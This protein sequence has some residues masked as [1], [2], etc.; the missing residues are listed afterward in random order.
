MIDSAGPNDWVSG[1]AVSGDT[2]LTGENLTAFLRAAPSPS[3]LSPIGGSF[4]GVLVLPDRIR[5]ISDRFGSRPVFYSRADSGWLVASEFWTLADRL[6]ALVPSAG[7]AV[8]MLAFKFIPGNETISDRISETA[9]ATCLDLLDNGQVEAH[10]Y[11]QFRPQ[12]HERSGRQLVAELADVIEGMATRSVHAGSLMGLDRWGINLTAG[13]DS[14]LILAGLIRA[15]VPVTAYSS[16]VDSDASVARQLARSVGVRHRT[17]PFWTE[18]GSPWVPQV[19]DPLVATTM[20]AVAGH[21]LSLTLSRSLDSSGWVS[22]HLGD[23]FNASRLTCGPW[24]APTAD[25]ETVK[26]RIVSDSLAVPT[27]RLAEM[28]RPEWRE[29]SHSPKRRLR[30]VIESANVIKPEAL[31]HHFTFENRQR[32]FILR[33]Y[34]GLRALGPTVLWFADPAWADFWSTVPY[35]WRL[36]A[37]LYS[38]VLVEKVL[39]KDLA[40]LA[41]I[42]ANEQ[43]LRKVLLPRVARNRD[44]FVRKASKRVRRAS[45][46]LQPLWPSPSGEELELAS[47]LVEPDYF[48]R[49]R[50]RS[51][52]EAV[53]SVARATELLYATGRTA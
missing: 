33:D 41:S 28:L 51:E 17:N 12:P 49:P 26:D 24:G 30:Q 42:P 43:R 45:L 16:D 13:R 15:G 9:A 35:R 52:V 38:R 23:S 47:W 1:Y 46:G 21:P 48:S 50:Q 29:L 5:I 44:E 14:R 27:G 34:M 19:A 4:A 20:A 31:Y 6:G 18:F 10:L 8:D 40:P 32:R 2:V 25:S 39:V 37:P 7:S 11:W 36:G 22:G 53:R 3:S